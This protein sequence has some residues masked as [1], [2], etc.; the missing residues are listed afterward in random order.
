MTIADRTI[1]VKCGLKKQITQPD[2]FAKKKSML[3]SLIVDY[4]TFLWSEKIT[5]RKSLVN[6]L[7]RP[8]HGT[9]FIRLV[10]PYTRPRHI[11]HLAKILYPSSHGWYPYCQRTEPSPCNRERGLCGMGHS[12][13]SAPP[14]LQRDTSHVYAVMSLCLWSS[15]DFLLFLVLHISL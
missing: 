5:I 10:W 7:R 6:D 13:S 14:L 4:R 9:N 8:Q 15:C 2:I 1:I 12:F 3:R 11:Q